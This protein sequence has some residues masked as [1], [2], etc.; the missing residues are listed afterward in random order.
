MKK[1]LAVLF[2]LFSVVFIYAQESYFSLPIR[3]DFRMSG[4]FGE[5][6]NNHF[7]A[8]VD[9]KSSRGRDGDDIIAAAPGYISRIK[10]QYGGYGRA[11]Y[12][13]HPNG[14][15]TVYAH[16]MSFT[17][18]IEALVERHQL[19]SMSYEVDLYPEAG[20]YKVER[21]EFIGFMGNTGHS[22]GTHLHFEIRETKSEIPQNPYNFGI[23]PADSKFPI[24]YGVLISEMGPSLEELSSTFKP[25][26]QGSGGRYTPNFDMEVAAGKTGVGVQVFDQMDG[27]SNLNGIYDLKMYV[28]DSLYF[29]HTMDAV[30]FDVTK[31]I[32]SHI[33]FKAKVERDKTVTRCYNLPGNMLNFY[34]QKG[35]GLIDVE[36]GQNYSVRV[37]AAD[38][39]GN[40]SRTAFT[41]IG[42]KPGNFTSSTYVRKILQG[43]KDTVRIGKVRLYFTENSLDRDLY[44]DY[45]YSEIEGAVNISL[46]DKHVPLFQSVRLV[47]NIAHL[48]SST[49][50]KLVLVNDDSTP[51]SYGGIVQNGVFTTSIRRLGQ[52]TILPDH[53]APEIKVIRF[54]SRVDNGDRFIFNITDNFKTRGAARDLEFKVYIDGV[55]QIANYSVV[56]KNLYVPVKDLSPGEHHLQVITTDHSGNQS[57]WNGKFTVNK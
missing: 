43:E 49:W 35:N 34:Y 8:G 51:V 3:H 17:P 27:A 6:R 1:S 47:A 26:N 29:H 9:M 38:F 21:E 4:S 39:L 22:Y 46:N 7:H 32:N 16:L 42:K 53:T 19:E 44:L 20:K 55:W 57:Q 12:I 54:S 13:D 56:S 30:G 28:D 14:Y 10:V 48:D 40:V 11:L 36:E 5:L 24:M 2:F 18:E 31:Y 37:E 52:F 41:L 25:L 15:T 33:D 50:D 45:K 23:G